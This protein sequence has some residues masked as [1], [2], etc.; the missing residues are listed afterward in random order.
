MSIAARSGLF[1]LFVLATT[2]A[3]SA[4]QHSP[5]SQPGG[6]A[7][8][9]DVV[10]TP[11]SGP[12]VSGLG[13]QDFTVI[14]NQ[15]PQTI[16]SFRAVSG[17][18][19]HVEI[20]LVL[21]AVN[22]DFQRVAFVREQIDKFLRADGGRLARPTS[23]AFFT[24]K[25]VQIQQGV[26]TDGNAL[27]AAVNQYMI[28]LRD[29]RRSSM[30]EGSDRFNLSL[31]A[32]GELVGPEAGR[33]GRKFILWISPG[34]PL[35]SGPATASMID[36]KQQ[37]QI[38]SDIVRL[39]TQLREARITLYSIDPLGAGESEL[40]ASYY[41]DFLKGVREPSQVQP[42]NLAL[43]VLAT[44]TGGL[45]LNYNNDVS[46]LLRECVADAQA[47][48]ELTFDAPPA[49]KPDEYHQLEVKLAKPGLTAR[50][51]QGYYAQPAF[52]H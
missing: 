35:L 30:Y 39:S 2:H 43:E 8:H 25:G 17:S 16:T 42:G 4:P 21:D 28:G 36:E 20:L 18:D 45:A 15:L 49:D 22:M 24:D 48:Y 3:F 51:R 52:R 26:S 19:A 33:P 46:A 44:Q 50:T 5:R 32:L 27:S 41:K 12:P 14:D 37:Q 38:F 1:L 7:I 47:Y 40:R 13:Q 11:K 6:N 23:L 31:Q 9:L 10:V 29:V 34:W